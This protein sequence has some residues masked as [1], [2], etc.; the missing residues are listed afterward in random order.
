MSEGFP[1]YARLSL[2]GGTQLFSGTGTIPENA[3]LFQGYVGPWPYLNLFADPTLG[4]ENVTIVIEW[5]SDATFTTLTAFRYAVRNGQSISGTQYANM[6]PWVKVFYETASGL[7]VHWDILALFGAT[8]IAT[9]NQLLSSDAPIQQSNAL[10]AANT[11]LTF[12]PSHVT[13]GNAQITVETTLA[14]WFINLFYTAANSY[15]STFHHRI[16]SVQNAGGGSYC[17]PLLDAPYTITVKNTTAA[18][19]NINWSLT[20]RN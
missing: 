9:P 17:V 12:N 13:H 18:A 3:I 5:F 6:S 20:M 15:T 4:A 2:A 16:S 7:A 1:D 8:S 11:A 14:T 10:I 19:G